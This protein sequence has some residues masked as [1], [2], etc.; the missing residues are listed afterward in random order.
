MNNAINEIDKVA[1]SG[2]ASA[3]ELSSSVS[4]FETDKTTSFKRDN[5]T[6]KRKDKCVTALPLPDSERE[7]RELK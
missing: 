2:A 4:I 7:W 5:A 3:E 1:Q 6:S